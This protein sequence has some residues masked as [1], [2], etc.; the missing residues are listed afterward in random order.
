MITKI[1]KN[2]VSNRSSMIQIIDVLIPFNWRSDHS[3][4]S[5][6]AQCGLIKM[7]H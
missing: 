2:F 6:V 3:R 1:N 4:C 5:F 7:I